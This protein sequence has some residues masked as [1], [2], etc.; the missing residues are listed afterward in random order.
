[1]KRKTANS[2]K[3]RFQ[4]LVFGFPSFISTV[5]P[6]K[7]T[8]PSR[9]GGT[10]STLL[11]LLIRTSS[12]PTPTPHRARDGGVGYEGVFGGGGGPSFLLAGKRAFTSSIHLVVQRRSFGVLEFFEFELE[13]EWSPLTFVW[14]HMTVRHLICHYSKKNWLVIANCMYIVYYI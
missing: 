5:L 11:C 1:M 6:R 4:F 13:F 12:S 10:G 3:C 7:R 2:W 9:C 8:A 14:N